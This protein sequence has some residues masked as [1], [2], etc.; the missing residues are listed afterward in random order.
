MTWFTIA[1]QSIYG[2]VLVLS[3]KLSPA[4]TADKNYVEKLN[5]LPDLLIFRDRMRGVCA[6]R[7]HPQSR[8]CL[9]IFNI[10]VIINHR[11]FELC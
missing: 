7:A 11:K 5:A 6:V 8:L 1:F 3:L 4:I 10:P 9:A 2:I